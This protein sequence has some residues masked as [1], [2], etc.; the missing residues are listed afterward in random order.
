MANLCGLWE[1]VSMKVCTFR[2]DCDVAKGVW[3]EVLLKNGWAA[4]KK[5]V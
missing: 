2:F 5:L 3:K 1:Y 4:E